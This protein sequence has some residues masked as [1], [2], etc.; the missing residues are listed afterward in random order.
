MNRLLA[1]LLAASLAVNLWLGW[2]WATTSAEKEIPSPGPA[3][4]A[5]SPA[6]SADSSASSRWLSDTPPAELR[7]KLAAEGVSPALIRAILRER[8]REK[9]R[10]EW[11]ASVETTPHRADWWRTNR[12][13]PEMQERRNARSKLNA[14]IEAELDDLLGKQK[15]ARDDD[16]RYWFLSPEKAEAVRQILADYQP[17]HSAYANDAS[18]RA[19]LDTEQ[20]RDLAGVLSPAELAEYEVRFAPQTEQL[21][22]RASRV[23]MSEAEFRRLL[24]LQQQFDASLLAT[25]S[26]TDRAALDADYIAQVFRTLGDERAPDFLW[27]SDNAYHSAKLA[28]SAQQLPVQP[29]TELLRLQHDISG[30]AAAI[31]FAAGGTNEAK[32]AALRDLAA[33]ARTRLARFT[34]P[35]FLFPA[36][37]IA[38]IDELDRGGVWHNTWA[39]SSGTGTRVGP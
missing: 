8:L 22:Y 7:Q 4:I 36:N 24:G 12:V 17:L 11:V 15:S 35:G 1:T 2:K 5:P 30:R 14:R 39:N 29:A 37:S 10:S 32:R 27:S 19:I 26:V 31:A 38:W 34:P 20:R 25:K 16:V 6:I 33:E 9:Y 28:L 18:K 21:R 13:T 23:D 3:A